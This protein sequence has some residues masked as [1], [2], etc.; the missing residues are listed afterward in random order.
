MRSTPRSVLPLGLLLL[1]ACGRAGLDGLLDSGTG[2]GDAA[3]GG[4]IGSGGSNQGGSNQG[5]ASQGGSN[6]G[7]ASQGGSNQGGAGQGGAGMP[8]C[9]DGVVEGGEACDDGNAS[10]TDACVDG[11]VVAACGDGYV[12]E[13]VEDCDTGGT[14]TSECSAICKAPFCGDGL[15]GPNEACDLGAQ[16]E[17][18]YALSYR[19]GNGPRV[20]VKPHSKAQSATSFYNF[21]SNSGHTGFE[22][23]GAS[24]LYFYRNTT[25]SV[26]S[27]VVHHSID[28]DSSGI[29]TPQSFAEFNFT[30]LPTSTFVALADDSPQEFNKPFNDPTRARGNWGFLDNTDGGVLANWPIPGNWKATLNAQW[31]G[32]PLVWEFMDGA[33]QSFAPLDLAS[34][35]VL[36]AFSQPSACRLDC[37]VPS[38]GDGILDG[39]EVCD[40]G[41]ANGTSG[42]A[43]NCGALL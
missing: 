42:C 27:L 4:P 33:T 18:R 20:G 38:C 12:R 15:L 32:A 6:Q 43:S 39:G 9:G 24:R 7:G 36:E 31:G 34:P 10:N 11:C 5:G 13:G 14:P 17:D 22:A 40:E 29:A 26:L 19:Q 2:G 30:G 41:A 21:F 1:A 28:R 35:L 23:A 3:G 25:N 37:S 8:V 16:N